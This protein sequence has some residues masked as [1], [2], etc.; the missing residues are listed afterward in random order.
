MKRLKV[1]IVYIIQ[2]A[3]HIMLVI[4]N[5]INIVQIVIQ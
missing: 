2:E 5:I 3:V 4:I 1:N